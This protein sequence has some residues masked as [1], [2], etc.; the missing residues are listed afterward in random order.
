MKDP[1]P[2]YLTMRGSVKLMV[3]AAVALVVVGGT[4]RAQ[5]GSLMPIP[6]LG[7]PGNSLSVGG[8]GIPLGAT[9]LPDSGLSP[10]PL[11]A[12]AI[13]PTM[14]TTSMAITGA[15]PGN[16][17]SSNVSPPGSFAPAAPSFGI[18]NFGTGGVQSLPGSPRSGSA[19]FDH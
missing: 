2:V 16:G 8:T 7:M 15:V 10:S 12:S 4:A 11:G 5:L 6:S 1:M 18:T 14:P 9:E 3:A 13:A 17:L 19:G